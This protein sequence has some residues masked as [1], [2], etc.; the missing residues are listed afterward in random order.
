MKTFRISLWASNPVRVDV[1]GDLPPS[2]LADLKFKIER[3]F[4][5]SFL[6][7][8]F[9]TCR[10]IN[11]YDILSFT[12]RTIIMDCPFSELKVIIQDGRL[13][14]DTVYHG[15]GRDPKGQSRFEKI[16]HSLIDL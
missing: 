7:S 10:N 4:D 13:T 6:L 5:R 11:I 3:E 14:Y 8:D 9:P 12:V 16:G 2:E 1:T 15:V